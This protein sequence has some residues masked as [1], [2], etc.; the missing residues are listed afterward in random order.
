MVCHSEN[1]ISKSM[2]VIG[3]MKMTQKAQAKGLLIPVYLEH[4]SKTGS[5]LAAIK[6]NES[7][8]SL[9]YAIF[10]A[11]INQYQFETAS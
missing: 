10:G 6:V 4:L 1:G 11:Q 8:K 9:Q 5:T 3:G 7:F 2:T